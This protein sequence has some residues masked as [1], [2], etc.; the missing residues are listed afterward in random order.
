MK[1]KV[2]TLFFTGAACAL[3][4]SSVSSART[5]TSAD[6]KKTF[7]G[8]LV[9]YDEAAGK[10]TVDMNGREVTFSQDK[11]SADDI[12]F[13]KENGPKLAAQAPAGGGG[14][15]GVA[16]AALPDTLPDPDGKEADMSKPVQVF[17]LMGQSNMLGFGKV[18]QLQSVAAD[19]Y[20]YLVDDAGKWITRKDVRNVFFVSGNLK[21]ND[22][23]AAD[24][25]GAIG[26][27]IGIGNYL[28]H[29]IDAPV[30]LL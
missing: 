14:G 12:A 13:A 26:P 17:V 15:G 16:V 22:W 30:M 21:T 29:A 11:L 9:A 27:E 19:K 5:W 25:R 4:L 2:S 23:M 3:L 24:N 18:S 6:G 20:P 28:G 10:V 8:A 1:S 7:E